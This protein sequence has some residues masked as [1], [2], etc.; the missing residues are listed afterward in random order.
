MVKSSDKL[1]N[2]G[3]FDLNIKKKING[4]LTNLSASMLGA[5]SCIIVYVVDCRCSRKRHMVDKFNELKA[6]G[7]LCIEFVS[8]QI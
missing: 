5:I 7:W 4:K 8:Y 2:Y 6:N 3:M 1:L